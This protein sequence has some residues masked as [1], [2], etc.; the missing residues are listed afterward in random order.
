MSGQSVFTHHYRNNG[1]LPELEPSCSRK[2]EKSQWWHNPR[3]RLCSLST[4]CFN[5]TTHNL[6]HDPCTGAVRGF[7]L[8]MERLH[9]HW[10]SPCL[11]WSSYP[12]A[13]RLDRY[14]PHA[15]AT[16]NT[17]CRSLKCPP[18]LCICK[19]TLFWS[20]WWSSYGILMIQVKHDCSVRTF[21]LLTSTVSALHSGGLQRCT[22]GWLFHPTAGPSSAGIA[23]YSS[24]SPETSAY[25]T[26]MNHH[27]LFHGWLETGDTKMNPT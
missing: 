14:G 24:V 12:L 22:W 10:S 26:E 16:L 8:S 9:S 2:W 17:S 6:V 27:C 4:V 1:V 5:P 18:L 7:I 19:M 15:P 20:T 25:H 23:T 21:L 11:S 3:T 13:G